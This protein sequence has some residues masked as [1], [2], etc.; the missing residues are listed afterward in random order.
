MSFIQQRLL[1]EIPFF[2]NLT[3]SS[4][5]SPECNPIVVFYPRNI[6]V[7]VVRGKLSGDCVLQ[8]SAASSSDS[9]MARQAARPNSATLDLCARRG[10]ERLMF[11]RI[12]FLVAV[13]FDST[14]HLTLVASLAIDK[15]EPLDESAPRIFP[16][17]CD[18]HLYVHRD[19]V[20]QNCG[21]FNL[22]Y[23]CKR[24]ILFNSIVLVL[25]KVI[26]TTPNE[27]SE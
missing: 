25:G 18:C 6:R 2:S 5:R 24:L 9:G 27:L 14:V 15:V 3:S 19:K 12:G 13:P 22:Q 11:P 26:M 1:R 17:Q 23:G 8:R 21:V 20:K 7:V 16:R 4:K 10:R